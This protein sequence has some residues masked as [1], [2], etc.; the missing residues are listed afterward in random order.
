MQAKYPA[1]CAL[2]VKFTKYETNVYVIFVKYCFGL[3]TDC[4]FN[5]LRKKAPLQFTVWFKPFESNFYI[6]PVNIAFI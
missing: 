4:V 6:S 3:L 2:K 1:L 5:R